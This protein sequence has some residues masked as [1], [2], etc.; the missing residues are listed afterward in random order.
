[1][2]ERRHP[3]AGLG[4][5]LFALL[6]PCVRADYAVDLTAPVELR[7]LL[8]DNL[9]LFRWRKEPQVGESQLRYLVGQAPARVKEL[10]ET[11]GYY[12]PQVSA[13]LEGSAGAWRVNLRVSPGQAARVSGLDLRLAGALVAD[14]EVR[15]DYETR[16][17]DRWSLPAGQVFRHGDWEAAK[18]DALL[19]LLS[20]AYPSA[21]IADSQATVNPDQHQ[22]AL[23]LTL[24]SGPA[25]T[26]GELQVSGLRRYPI[27]LVRRL[28]PIS[29]GQ[30]YSQAKLLDFQARLRNSPYF[31]SVSVTTPVDPAQPERVPVQVALEEK[32]S[33]HLALGAGASTDAGPRG[34]IE[35]GDLN[36]L[37]KAWRLGVKL[38]A[39][40]KRQ[41]LGAD[42]EF[43]QAQEGHKNSL[44]AQHERTDIEDQSTR[45]WRLGAKRSHLRDDVETVLALDYTNQRQD[46]VGASSDYNQ[47]LTATYTWTW[48]R[49]DDLVQPRR[50]YLI[51]LQTGGGARALLSDQDFLRNY[52]RGAW[53]IPLG[54]RNDLILRGEAGAVLADSG[55]GIPSDFLFR[56]GGDQSVRGYAYQSI[57]VAEGQAVVGGR[58]LAV[59]SAEV[60]HWFKPQ[61]GGALFLDAGDAA[62]DL[63][64]LSPRQG[65]GLG[66]RWKSPVGPL[67][68]D[69]AQSGETQ[70][71]RL[72]FSASLVF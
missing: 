18:R 19:S 9:D 45:G 2:R 40:A 41:T 26:F 30:P 38:T 8:T 27:K 72:H 16:L 51:S 60:V 68:L 28:N 55:K 71:L 50:G 25:Y 39:D 56:T 49:V 64:D 1:M 65:Y 58:W 57:G 20:G 3:R 11:E 44:H 69:L 62:D 24:D 48:R 12:D 46:V 54:E 21:H 70:D 15:K 43:P 23:S 53:F 42:L 59:A 31:A 67:N 63:D 66:L 47:A 29:P 17:R 6:V 34:S 32:P 33:K 52:A 35:Y 36:L 22:V 4:L 10:L 14:P 37:D 5:L 13:S 7:A 61:W